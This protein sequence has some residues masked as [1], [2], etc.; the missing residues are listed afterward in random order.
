[1][2]RLAI[3]GFSVALSLV[4]LGQARQR[5][6][7]GPTTTE[8]VPQNAGAPLSGLS[9]VELNAFNTGRGVFGR[10]FNA[11][12]GLGPVFND[13]SC[14]ACHNGAA[15]GGGS[16][17]TVTRFATLT[18]GAYDPLTALGGSLEQSRAIGPRN[19]STHPF[20]PETVPAQ[21]T[22][23]VLRRTTPLFGLGLVD[24]TPDA[25]FVSL[26][27]AEA[28]RGDGVVGRVNMVDN[29]RAGMKTVGRFGW[30][31]QVP[32]LLQFAGDALVN[33]MGI[34]TPDFPNENCPQ[35][36][37]A[38]LAFNPAPGLNDNGNA[39]A[40]L[41]NFMTAL[42]APAR[43]PQNTATAAGEQTF[44]AIGCTACHTVSLTTGSSTIAALDHKIYHPY[45]DFLLHDMGSLGDG[46]E[47]GDSTRSEM[48]TEPLWG[49]RF[50]N[51]YLHDG[52]AT[53]LDQ[54]IA[55]HDGQAAPSRDQYNALTPAAKQQLIAF[56]QSL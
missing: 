18:N 4:L 47:M 1:M 34:T 42:A 55:A 8:T 7:R 56:L 52:R 29:L 19:G 6:V 33:E 49:L 50:V 5:A 16:P 45:S 44:A 15:P 31:A 38:E 21:A 17:R 14:G 39:S 26:A 23:V 53:T 35:G 30:K 27:A 32:S 22:L 28:A 36:N 2:R 11:A 41:N 3:L 13:D 48:R 43:G 12:S 46:L 9:A 25:T 24:A 20:A 10:P 37:C 40:A 51:R 54:A